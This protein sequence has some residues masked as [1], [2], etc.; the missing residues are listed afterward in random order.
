MKRRATF[1]IALALVALVATSAFAAPAAQVRKAYLYKVK[2][3][4][5][6]SLKV[7][8]SAL[9]PSDPASGRNAITDQKADWKFETQPTEL[10]L[11]KYDGVTTSYV[12]KASATDSEDHTGSIT[13]SELFTYYKNHDPT[14]ALQG[15]SDCHGTVQNGITAKI[16]AN[17]TVAG[18]SIDVDLTGGFRASGNK[19]LACDNS[20]P[21]RDIPGE[22]TGPAPWLLTW[23]PDEAPSAT[24]QKMHLYDLLQPFQVGLRS[25]HLVLQGANQ[26][27]TTA[28]CLDLQLACDVTFK[29]DGEAE[30]TL[31][32]A[33]TTVGGAAPS[34]GSGGGGGSQPPQKNPPPNP[35]VP[36]VLTKLAVSPRSFSLS[37]TAKITYSVN[38][39][40]T[41]T[42][43]KV[44]KAMKEP[45]IGTV[46]VP[47]E[48]FNHSNP[49]KAVSF[50]LPKSFAGRPL[51]PGHYTLQATPSSSTAG[52]GKQVTTTFDVSG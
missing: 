47:V 7:T 27:T 23:N 14:K 11:V 20:P 35:H 49:T 5:T 38:Q 12:T 22:P 19:G 18:T 50:D 4:G 25:V 6:G 33:T 1:A 45:V 2:L 34:C 52:A 36:P 44:V 29:L 21:E 24:N 39:A 30:L 13:S 3:S 17:A 9:V 43:L 51:A 16:E 41:T 28:E 10:W 15:T 40:G 37:Q 8:G 46:F 31:V 42:L 26:V 48:I 32:C